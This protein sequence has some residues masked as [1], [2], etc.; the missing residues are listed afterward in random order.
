MKKLIILV[1]LVV[2]GG[3]ASTTVQKTPSFLNGDTG[4]ETNFTTMTLTEVNAFAPT[5]SVKFVLQCEVNGEKDLS[6]TRCV[7]SNAGRQDSAPGVVSGF[8]GAVINSAAIVGGAYLM[9][10]GIA[11]S[12]DIS[13]EIIQTAPNATV[14]SRTHNY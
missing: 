14:G 4:K 1:V 12:G 11:K 3:C 8:G 10:K 13:N 9:G 7:P 2:I 5:T 6:K